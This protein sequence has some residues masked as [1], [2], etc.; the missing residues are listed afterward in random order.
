MEWPKLLSMNWPSVSWL[1]TDQDIDAAAEEIRVTMNRNAPSN[2]ELCAVIRWMAGP[3]CRQ[4][5]A[6][7]LRELIRAVYIRRKQ[8]R[9]Q[10]APDR[11]PCAMCRAGW[12]WYR[13]EYGAETAIPCMCSEGSRLTETLKEYKDMAPEQRGEFD[14]RRRQ[15]LKDR[16]ARMAA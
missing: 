9:T 5:K 11:A 14:N 2:D 16:G 10:Q 12:A 6:P 13:N 7:S 4:E 8:N 1:R 15:A 3:E